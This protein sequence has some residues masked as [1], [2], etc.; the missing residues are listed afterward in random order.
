MNKEYRRIVSAAS[1]YIAGQKP[2]IRNSVTAIIDTGIYPHRDIRQNVTG[3]Y[4]IVQSHTEAY[5][6]NGHGTHVAGII[7]GNPGGKKRQLQGVFPYGKIFVVKALDKDGNGKVKNFIT[8]MEYLLAHREEYQI[9]TIN[10]SLGAEA[11]YSAEQKE[12]IDCVEHAW[13]SG[14]TICAAAGNNGPGQGSVTVPGISRK[15]I[16]VGTYDDYI[17]MALSNDGKEKK[18]YSGQGPTSDCVVKPDI[19]CPGSNILSLDN[20]PAGYAVKSGTSMSTPMISA[21]AAIITAVHPDVTPK[22]LKKA[23]KDSH[24][25]GSLNFDCSRFFSHF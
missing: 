4:D 3:F 16:T 9:R 14:I 2:R 25:P 11:D 20:H 22:E 10:I 21:L 12:L 18:N 6:D 15:I 23:F 19:L 13:D 8:G 17:P 24:P 7:C 5:D 1:A